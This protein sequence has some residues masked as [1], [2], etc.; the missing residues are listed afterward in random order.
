MF[1]EPNLRTYTWRFQNTN[2]ERNQLEFVEFVEAK[3]MT[4]PIVLK[5][6]DTDVQLVPDDI[7]QLIDILAS[8]YEMCQQQTEN[9]Q[10]RNQ[11]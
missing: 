9:R 8:A 3:T 6:F 11:Q 7:P 2:T 5:A 1:I 10:K 4:S